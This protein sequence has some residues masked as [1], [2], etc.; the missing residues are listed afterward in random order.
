V[1][2]DQPGLHIGLRQHGS[3]R[4]L[5]DDELGKLLISLAMATSQM[6]NSIA[7]RLSAEV[8]VC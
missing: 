8:P 4:L 1:L 7:V 2:E 6:Q 3:C 5:E